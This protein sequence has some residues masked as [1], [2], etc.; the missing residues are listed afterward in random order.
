[1]SS[2]CLDVNAVTATGGKSDLAVNYT[3]SFRAYLTWRTV[4]S[5]LTAMSSICLEVDTIT[6]AVIKTDLAVDHALSAGADF[7]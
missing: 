1:M 5:T 7:T 2:I 4:V 6:A 3:I